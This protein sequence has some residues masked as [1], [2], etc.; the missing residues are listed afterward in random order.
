MLMISSLIISMISSIFAFES[1]DA[2]FFK[3]S[4][5]F[6]VASKPIS[7]EI[8]IS[9]ISSSRFWSSFFPIPIADL[10]LSKMFERVLLNPVLILSTDKVSEDDFK[11]PETFSLNFSNSPIL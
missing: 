6:S 9:S 1:L 8:S 7:A 10:S 5:I 4:S 11:K 3:V 2:F